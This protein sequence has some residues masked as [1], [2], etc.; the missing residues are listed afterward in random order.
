MMEFGNFGNQS[1]QPF[2][3][4]QMMPNMG[5]YPYGYPPAMPQQMIQPMQF[6]SFGQGLYSPFVSPFPNPQPYQP[7]VPGVTAPLEVQDK[8]GNVVTMPATGFN[9]GGTTVSQGGFNPVSGVTTPPAA[10][11]GFNPFTRFIG[12]PGYQVPN[13]PMMQPQQGF[14]PYVPQPRPP[15]FMNGY[16]QTLYNAANA[17]NQFNFQQTL[18]SEEP[19]VTDIENIL[20]QIVLSDEEREKINHNQQGYVVGYD[21]Y[22]NP[23]YNNGYS[24]YQANQERQRQFEEARHEFQL[25]CTQLSK[26]AH[27]Y[28]GETIDEEATMRRFDPIPQQPIQKQFNYY[29]ATPKEREDYEKEM[30]YMACQDLISKIPQ[31]DAMEQNLANQRLAM[32]DQIKASHD[33]LLGVEPGQHYD[34]KTYLDNGYKIGVNAAMQQARS[35]SRNG[36]NKYSRNE[37][38]AGLSMNTNSAIPITSKDDEYVSVENILKNVYNRNRMADSIMRNQNGQTVYTSEAVSPT[39]FERHRLFLEKTQQQKAQDEAK[40]GY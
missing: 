17:Q 31:I 5:G 2:Y 13:M 19:S 35:D 14:S 15:M 38:R 1:P 12:N 24:A 28:S 40:R 16:Y 37:F 6:P 3:Q 29:T 21:Y 23:I 10:G 30:Q 32:M 22:G 8:S 20:R 39:E 18:Y 4:N 36:T 7:P 25:Y 26:V 11:L 33:K 27:A 34:L 9:P